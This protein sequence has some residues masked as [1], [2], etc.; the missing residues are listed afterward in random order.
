MFTFVSSLGSGA[1]VARCSQPAPPARWTRPWYCLA[2]AAIVLAAC[3]SSHTSASDERDGTYQL[4][5][6]DG[7]P[8]PYL[9]PHD[10]PTADERIRAGSRLV[11]SGMSWHLTWL[12]EWLDEAGIVIPGSA[13]E[14]VHSGI[15]SH[16]AST[17]GFAS[18][19]WT[20]MASGTVAGR[21]ITVVGNDIF[22]GVWLQPHVLVF[23]R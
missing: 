9:I 11:L 10:F 20:P 21:V 16:G 17:I 2:F 18:G 7:H 14:T 15:V 8:L 4:L 6:I 1:R 13:R 19:D 22:I 5:S 23:S 12:K 3:G